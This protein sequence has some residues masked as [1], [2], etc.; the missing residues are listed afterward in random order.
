MGRQKLSAGPEFLG[1]PGGLPLL[2]AVRFLVRKQG[3]AGLFLRRQNCKSPLTMH[4]FP[5]HQV[6]DL[7]APG[8][9]I[10]APEFLPA[11]VGG[12]KVVPPALEQRC[13]RL[14]KVVAPSREPHASSGFGR[15]RAIC[16]RLHGHPVE[17][18][19]NG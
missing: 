8:H 13:P 5:A 7:G 12:S 1:P 2:G 4:I 10:R 19:E 18:L 9:L 3:A 6:A 11:V 15:L 16:T 17:M 14:G